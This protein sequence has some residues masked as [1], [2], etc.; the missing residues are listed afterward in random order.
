MHDVRLAAGAVRD[1]DDIR[2]PDLSR[3]RTR[4]LSLELEPRPF[5]TQKLKG[6]LHRIRVG[7]WRILYSVDDKQRVVIVLR[8]LRRSERTYKSV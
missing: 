8:V 3:L 1:L 5:G 7:H 4:I 2:G 6:L